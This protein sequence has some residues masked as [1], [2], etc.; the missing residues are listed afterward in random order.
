M[1]ITEIISLQEMLGLS[2]VPITQATRGP[3]VQQPPPS[4]R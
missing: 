4:N 3:Q 2:K 1:D